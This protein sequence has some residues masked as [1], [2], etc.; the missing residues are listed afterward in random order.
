[1]FAKKRYLL[2][3]IFF[4]PLLAHA[5]TAADDS[6]D[7][8]V[9]EFTFG[10]NAFKQNLPFD[11]IFTIRFKDVPT[12]VVKIKVEFYEFN[13]KKYRKRLKKPGD[14]TDDILKEAYRK[15]SFNSGTR[16]LNTDKDIQLTIPVKLKP[17]SD[18]IFKIYG[19]TSKALT[20]AEKNAIKNSPE[21][22]AVFSNFFNEIGTTYF[23]NREMSN[24]NLANELDKSLNKS[25]K[26]ELKNIDETY[27]LKEVNDLDQIMAISR[28]VNNYREINDKLDEVTA[29]L[30]NDSNAVSSRE[31]NS[32]FKNLIQ[33]IDFSTI[34]LGSADHTTL[35]NT[36]DGIT[37][38][39]RG[40]APTTVNSKKD[41][42]KTA[43]NNLITARQG[44][45]S[46]LKVKFLPRV[47]KADAIN[48]T[49]RADFFKN[50][51]L[52]ITLDAGLAYTWRIDRALF[53]TGT[54]IYFRP[55]NKNIPLSSYKRFIDYM[56]VRSSLLLGVTVSE[57]KKTNVR[58]GLI[59]NTALVLGAGFRV[60]PFLKINGGTMV[61][62]RYN[63]NPLY[64]PD[65][66]YTTFSPFVSLSLD[67]DVKSLIGGI[68]TSLFK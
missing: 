32:A 61:Y 41:A 52:Y 19:D 21:I 50:A 43:I 56:A 25:Y 45:I 31:S 33:E 49:Y 34:E 42:C 1:M 38:N 59:G 62:Y 48:G 5:Q 28:I 14:I 4:L 23:E 3:L 51:K 37:S 11:Q 6:N 2:L 24:L 20:V 63:K 60:T 36:A 55:V 46:T 15:Y 29:A 53:Y 64:A 9:V 26:T 44:L 27:D 22:A 65:R 40:V 18:Y 16:F 12:A 10:D 58:E 67:L 66:Q 35:M 57:I 47:T 7:R 30:E 13:D 54:N 8:K 68:G 17:N 39:Y